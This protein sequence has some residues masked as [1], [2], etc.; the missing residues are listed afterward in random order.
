VQRLLLNDL[1]DQIDK[2]FFRCIY[3]I[4][5]K[6]AVI[7]MLDSIHPAVVVAIVAFLFYSFAVFGH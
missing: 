4:F 3:L 2:I 7:L 1:N 5:K 6:I